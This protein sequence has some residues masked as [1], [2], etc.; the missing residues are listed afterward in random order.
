MLAIDT[1]LVVRVLTGEKSQQGAQ[2]RS[3]I[4]DNDVF[5]PTTVMLETEW[6]LRSLYRFQAAAFADGLTAFVGLPHVYP[7]E[8][9]KL[10]KALAWTRQ[11][12]DFADAL[13]LAASDSCEA[14]I[15]FDRR[16]AKS[17]AAFSGVSVRH[18]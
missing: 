9:A 10:A 17:A 16:F 18:P 12:M 4:D 13:H 14:M 5:V 8:P 2:A 1:N 7:E 11:G 3:V 15:T 6:V